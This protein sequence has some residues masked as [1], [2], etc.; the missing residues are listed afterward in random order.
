MAVDEYS[1]WDSLV[2][3]AQKKCA[4]ILRRDVA[5]IVEKIVKDHIEKDIYGAYSPKPG[6]WKLSKIKQSVRGVY[7]DRVKDDTNKDTYK[8]RHTLTDDVYSEMSGANN[9]TLLTTTNTAPSPSVVPGWSFHNRRQGAFL[10]LLES[11]NMGIWKSGFPRPAIGNAQK[12]IDN[13]SRVSRAIENGIKR[14]FN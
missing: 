5:P 10:Q 12:E 9:D 8:R 3:A 7:E 2:A 4:T 6:A 13:S 14:E 1:D 11:G